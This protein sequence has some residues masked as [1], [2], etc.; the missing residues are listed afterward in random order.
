MRSRRRRRRGAV[1]ATAEAPSVSIALD[2]KSSDG[3]SIGLSVSK[4]V[5]TLVVGVKQFPP[6]ATPNTMPKRNTKHRYSGI[7]GE[8]RDLPLRTME[9]SAAERRHFFE[10]AWQQH[11]ARKATEARGQTFVPDWMK[12]QSNPVFQKS[13]G[14]KS[15]QPTKP[16]KPAKPAIVSHESGPESSDN[17]ETKQIADVARRLKHEKETGKLRAAAVAAALN[18]GESD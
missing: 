3:V 1:E 12:R 14:T 17:E 7:M 6:S 5:G 13:V 4:G 9:E 10:K 15:V 11:H 18:A 16:T 8:K 2:A